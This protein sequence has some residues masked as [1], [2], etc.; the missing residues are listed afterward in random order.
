MT[1]EIHPLTPDRWPDLE[2][3]FGPSGA[4]GGCWC[5]WFRMRSSEMQK[6]TSA[7]NRAGLKAIVDEGKPPGLLAYMDGDVAGWVSLDR[8]ERFAHL[9]HSRRLGRIDD[10]PVWSIVCFVVGKR[11]RQQ[12]LMAALLEAAV[13]Y[14]KERGARTVEAYPIEPGSDLQRFDGFTGIASTFR[15][16]GFIEVKRISEKQV[17]MRK[18]VR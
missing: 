9:E 18:E 12:R 16:A 3:L 11:F 2:A 8:R 4:W 7:K 10:R 6:S 1:T 17:M 15:K 5:M 13:E 14:A